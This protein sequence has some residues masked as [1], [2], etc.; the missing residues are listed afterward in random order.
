VEHTVVDRGAPR[1]RVSHI[2]F[3]LGDELFAIDVAHV[4]E[5]LELSSVT[6]LPL[7]PP[8]LLGVVNVRG[9]AVAV[10]DLR[11]KFGLPPVAHTVQSRIIVVE[12][13]LDGELVVLGGLADS[14]ED[15]VEL[16]PN[17]I[18]PPPTLGMRWRADLVLG[19]SDR[20]DRFMILLS[21][22]KLFTSD[23][24]AVANDS[25]GADPP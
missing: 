15:V 18:A 7:A 16:D 1:E 23:E 5:V 19:V 22:A 17:E 3:R 8:H 2:T 6:R 21:G 14:V 24:L 13:E 4:R 25:F 20:G 11:S 9:S 12:L 10:V